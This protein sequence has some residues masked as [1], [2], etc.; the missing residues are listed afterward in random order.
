MT[1]PEN[2]GPPTPMRATLARA[3][4]SALAQLGIEPCPR[5]EEIRLEHPANPANGD[6]S[7]NVAMAWA[8]RTGSSPRD[9]A[10]K[11]AAIV[12][13]AAVP[14]VQSIEIAG[15]GFLNFRL[16]DSWLHD[17]LTTVV[18][19][20]EADYARSDEGQGR[21][22]QLEF[23]S[24]NPTGPLHVGNGWWCAYGDAL[25]RVMSRCGWDVWR[26]Y[27]VNDTGGQVRR[28]G[29][30]LLARHAGEEVPEEGYQGAYVA[31]LARTYNGPT[32]DGPDAV[33][34]AGS[35]AAERI[36]ANIADS[37]A[38]LGIVFDSWFSQASIEESGAVA[39]TIAD[40]SAHGLVYEADGA[41]WLASTKG[42][43]SRDRV[44]RKSESLGGDFTYLAGDL[45]YHRNKFLVR[46]FDRVIDIF[47]ADH[48]G[49]VASLMAGVAALGI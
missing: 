11:V 9:L 30:S 18:L 8:K 26:E 40:L 22:V 3:L 28:L 25:G 34:Q 41:V 4:C 19:G 1:E 42:G 38:R 17:V 2:Q 46:G 12:D 24:A 37:L 16:A 7:S 5:P 10:A 44:L 20:G 43:D 6:W 45:A 35:W 49:Q 48:H 27:Y 14:H 29:M 31:E 21:R 47:G 36:L 23:V 33:I 32:G 39:E 13:D 15:A